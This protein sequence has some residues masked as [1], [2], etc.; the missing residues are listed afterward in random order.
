MTHDQHRYH[1]QRSPGQQLRRDAY[2]YI[3]QS[4]LYQ[5]AD[6]TQSTARGLRPARPGH[7]AGLE[8]G[9][10]H[11]IDIDQGH[12]GASAADREGFQHLVAEVSL[13]RAGIVLGLECSR[14]AR[15]NAG[16]QRLL[17]ICAHDD[18]LILD[19]DR[20]YDPTSFNDRALLG[21]KG[22]MS[23]FELHFLRAQLR[24][25]DIG[26]GP[27]RGTQTAAADRAGLRPARS[28]DPGPRRG[29]PRRPVAAVRNLR[30]HRLGVRHH[31]GLPGPAAAVPQ[32]PAR[33]GARAGELYWNSLG[34]NQVLNILHNPAYAGTY[35]YGRARHT[36]DLDGRPH[37]LAKPPDQLFPVTEDEDV[38]VI[39][40]E[41]VGQGDGPAGWVLA[42][43]WCAWWRGGGQSVVS[44]VT[45]ARA[46]CSST[47]DLRAAQAATRAW[48]ARFLTG[49]WKAAGGVVDQGDGVVAE[50]QVGGPAGQLE[51]VG[52]VPAGL[53]AGHG[54]H[55]VAQGDPLVQ[56]GQ[57]A[58]T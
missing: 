42:G 39:E 7:R 36:T 40:G 21:L 25:R 19:E 49:R 44:S 41:D 29:R 54:G 27:P 11:V 5:V 3:R 2:L 43:P 56:G 38:A 46:L 45:A 48:V 16:W 13:G 26:Q 37:T 34:H 6:D 15:D 22:Q 53:L 58:R 47:M 4:T 24:Q 1:R 17:Q 31:Q 10:I 33:S 50:Q 12:S 20:L 28:G 57:H 51:V 14:L 32:P 52:D 30:C 9:R 18:T 55:G 23:E 8:R 35:V